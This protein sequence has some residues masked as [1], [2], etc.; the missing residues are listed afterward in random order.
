MIVADDQTVPI[1][2]ACFKRLIDTVQYLL[3]RFILKKM[4][5][6]KN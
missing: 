1:F 6:P 5:S 3:R 2:C 4:D